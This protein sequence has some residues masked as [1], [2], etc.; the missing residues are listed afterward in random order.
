MVVKMINRLR[1]MSGQNFGYDPNGTPEQN[2]AAARRLGAVVQQA[3]DSVRRMRPPPL[4]ADA[5]GSLKRFREADGQASGTR[6]ADRC[7]RYGENL[8]CSAWDG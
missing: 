1:L 6:A 4:P 2:E 7:H 8:K 3:G 5:A